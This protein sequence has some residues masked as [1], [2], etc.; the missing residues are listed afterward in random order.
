M[1]SDE[2][3]TVLRSS[4]DC[5]VGMKVKHTSLLGKHPGCGEGEIT[6]ID[7]HGVHVRYIWNTTRGLYDDQW[8]RVAAATLER[9]N[10]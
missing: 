1:L 10:E 3:R 6:A 8:F 5:R 2:Q 7:D 4:A 9:I